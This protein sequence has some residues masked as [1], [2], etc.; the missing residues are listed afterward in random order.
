MLVLDTNVYLDVDGD[1]ALA[2]RVAAFLAEHAD[3]VGLS[4]VV[5]RRIQLL[6][7]VAIEPRP[8]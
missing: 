6:I 5:L 2:G 1:A 7:P 4:S 3:A 8:A